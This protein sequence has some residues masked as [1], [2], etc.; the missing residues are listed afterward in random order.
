[1]SGAAIDT[2]VVL[3]CLTAT[4]TFVD[5]SMRANLE[6]LPRFHKGAD[7][8]EVHT[9]QKGARYVR[10]DTKQFAFDVALPLVLQGAMTTCYAFAVYLA[11][12]VGVA[13]AAY[14]YLFARTA[15]AAAVAMNDPLKALKDRLS[16][17]KKGVMAR[18]VD[19][20]IRTM[21]ENTMASVTVLMLVAAAQAA[22][23]VVLAAGAA[24]YAAVAKPQFVWIY[25]KSVYVDEAYLARMSSA[26][27]FGALPFLGTVFFLRTQMVKNALTAVI[28]AIRR[29]MR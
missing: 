9:G 21:F 19:E 5:S 29:W 8:P 16:T 18:F 14:G 22:L 24:A 6:Q 1:M 27:T 26:T 12:S 25:K 13:T 3:T 17:S 20:A 2:V 4:L 28:A 11:V 15:A 23:T 10:I 7:G